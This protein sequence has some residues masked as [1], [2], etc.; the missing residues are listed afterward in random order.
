MKLAYCESALALLVIVFV[1]PYSFAQITRNPVW[2]AFSESETVAYNAQRTATK[3]NVSPKRSTVFSL[4][5]VSF[6]AAVRESPI[7][8]L[9]LDISLRPAQ[10]IIMIPMPDGT[11]A[12]FEYCESPILHP[13]LAAQYP[14]IHTYVGQG[15]DDPAATLRFDWT[16]MGFH[17]QILSPKGAVYVDPYYGDDDL[18]ASYYKRDAFK[19][20]AS[21]QCF[22]QSIA[23]LPSARAA[24]QSI[25]TRSG[26]QLRTYRLALAATGEYTAFWGS[27]ANAL[28]GMTTTINRVT[29]IYET[30]LSIRLELVANTEDL[31]YTDAGT[32]PYSNDDGFAM[33]SENISTVNS[34]I[35]SSNYDIGHVFSTGGGG[36]A[37]IRS[38]C[39]SQKAGGVTGSSSPTGDSFDVDF[40]AH[41]MGHQFGGN[42]TFNGA[43]GNCSGGNRNGAT[44]YEPGSGSTIQ[45]YAGICGVDDLQ[46]YSDPFFHHESLN[47]M[48]FHAS[49][50]TSCAAVTPSGNSEPTADAGNDYTIPAGTPFTLTGSG[51]DADVGD[52]L[53]YSWE[54]RDL[55]PQSNLSDGDDGAIPL[56]RVFSPTT[57]PSRTIPRLSTGPTIFEKLPTA[58]RSMDFRLIVRDNDAGHGGYADDDMVVT[59]DTSGNAFTVTAPTGGS[60]VDGSTTVT[61]DKGTTDQFPIS[62]ALVDILLSTD[63]GLTYGIVLA[64]NTANDGTELVTLPNI[65]TS[66]ARV[67]V[68]SEGNIF[69][70]VSPSNFNIGDIPA[71]YTATISSTDIPTGIVDNATV[72]STLNFPGS[73]TIT[74]INVTLDISHTWDSDLTVTLTS[75]D[76]TA[77]TLFSAI[78]GSSDNF[79]NTTLDDEASTAISSNAAPFTGTFRPSSPLSVLDSED[80]LGTWTLSIT[81]SAT[82]D[83]GTLNGWSIEV[84]GEISLSTVWVDFGNT[85]TE[86]GLETYPFNTIAEALDTVQTN[87]NIKFKAGSTVEIATINQDVT[88]TRGSGTGSV[89]LGG[90]TP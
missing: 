84:T 78:G 20:D 67:M 41:E 36:V 58:A 85:G 73:V 53:T 89:I 44:A 39:N 87:G 63:G 74:D 76:N 90:T 19:E 21:F 27:V 56:F 6:E 12:A 11:Q 75:P 47:E 3:P 30:E 37:Y 80:A 60:S 29:G 14:D 32:D 34:I 9:D 25:T 28:A 57:S 18:Y 83:Q 68:R 86:L 51:S 82:D 81:D 23:Q 5:P 33:L 70:N 31:I 10:A 79:T 43:N 48:F 24:A 4:N 16:P 42:H 46:S 61:W 64:S 7:E 26:S 71:A 1:T 35:G 45:A 62:T 54:Q 50:S 72:F 88:L 65:D 40:V 22:V 15:I 59:V 8:R 17:A 13:D 69:F 55:G 38:V 77:V 49:V 52:V 66:S 2:T